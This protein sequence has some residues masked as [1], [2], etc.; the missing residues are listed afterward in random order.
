MT[1]KRIDEL[2]EAPSVE[3]TDWLHTN[4]AGVD[5][6]ASLEKVGDSI[7]ATASNTSAL[8]TG[9]NLTSTNVQGQLDEL[10]AKSV[11]DLTQPWIF[12]TVAAFKAS[13]IEF[14]DGKTIH[15]N[16]R[17]ADFTKVTGTGTANTYNIIASTSVNQ[18]IVLSVKN[19]TTDAKS[20]GAVIDTD[21]TAAIQAVYDAGYDLIIAEPYLIDA[22]DS[23]YPTTIHNGGI[24]P[25]DDSTTTFVG[26]GRLTASDNDKGSY[27]VI[28]LK[29]STN[30]KI[31]NGDVF[32]DLTGHTD[33]GGEFGMGYYLDNAT[34]PMLVHCKASD[35]WGDGFYIGDSVGGLPCVGG[36][37]AHCVGD[38]NRR[39]NLSIVSWRQ[40]LV[41]YGEYK[42]AGR[43]LFTE[44]GFGIDIEPNPANHFI[45][46]TM[47][48]VR[49]SNNTKGGIQFV[50]GF[51]SNALGAGNPYRVT[52]TDH[53]SYRDGLN[54]GIR[55][56]FP[57][58]TNSNINI[59]T[60]IVGQ[61][62]VINPSVKEPKQLGI[63]FTRWIPT[64]PDVKIIDSAVYD[65]NTDGVTGG[66]PAALTQQCAYVMFIDDADAANQ[67]S[68]GKV[69]F[70]RPRAYESR[71]PALMTFPMYLQG[72][73]I[74][75]RVDNVTIVDPFADK[76]L[77]LAN[78]FVNWSRTL[79]G[80]I[81]Y[82]KR[83]KHELAGTT[84]LAA[85]QFSGMDITLPANGVITL[86][87][88][89]TSVGLE[90]Y[91][92]N[93]N[94][95]TIQIRPFTGDTI[96]TY[97]DTADND[98]VLR[99][100]RDTLGIRALAGGAGQWEVIFSNGA[101]APL[102]MLQTDI[103]P[104]MRFRAG[105]PVGIFTPRFYGER[106]L[107]TSTSPDTIWSA[108]GLT[109]NDWS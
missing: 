22:V 68:T 97:G 41:A 57:S 94:G 90:Y 70:I 87:P 36:Y 75:Q 33:T 54:G 14:P 89:D 9:S 43:Q 12:P 100:N 35:C 5:Y 30:V 67:T 16:D 6:K 29:D 74:G 106:V 20:F 15:L 52:S 32:G 62:T 53:V 64:A 103:Q 71:S 7:K 95:G 66:T 44:P 99:T 105:T 86:P 37:L 80:T 81:K 85:A 109:I 40:G 82:T 63:G 23:N 19:N 83:P 73:A 79:N 13:L 47:I 39:N 3:V 59:S 45:D 24:K 4:K 11:N 77:S 1:D 58:L 98:A 46:I 102:G 108:Y 91:F 61:I 28:N 31:I 60:P 10:D 55:F 65:C 93:P 18:S 56:A 51:L 2:T 42:N 72:E 92:D 96:L 69:E 49:T 25:S 21:S 107:D 84:P 26:N 104:G 76:Q 50:P 78:G 48:G 101:V 88:A 34:N 17:D 27:Q 8:T 38:N